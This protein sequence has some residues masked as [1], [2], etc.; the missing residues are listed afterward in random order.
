MKRRVV[1]LSNLFLC[2]APLTALAEVVVDNSP[3]TTGVATFNNTFGAQFPGGYSGD[4]FSLENDTLITGGAIFANA[5]PFF[6][7]V[8]TPA[9]FV[10]L[11][12]EGGSPGATPLIF[13]NVVLDAVDDLLTTSDPLL[14]RKHAS[15]PPQ[16][17]PAGDYWF[18]L[19]GAGVQLMQATGHYDDNHFYFGSD[20][21]PDLEGGAANVGNGDTFFTLEGEVAI[22]A[23]VCSGFY[24]PLAN[25]PVMARKNRVFPLK[26]EL[27][28]GDGFGLSDAHLTAAPVVQVLFSADSGGDAVDVTAEVLSSGQGFDGNQFVFTDDGLWQFNLQSKNYSAPGEYMVTAVSGDDSEYTIDPACVTSFLIK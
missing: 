27:F 6:G 15:I 20:G 2:I 7:E 13:E 10:V 12:D 1:A 14:A 17:L 5:F 26:M 11:P 23:L 19:A 16:L 25:Y 8:G 22:N 21:N 24:S 18:Y 4:R 9:V 3:D 28:D